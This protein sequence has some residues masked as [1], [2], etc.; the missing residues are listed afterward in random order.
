MGEWRLSDGRVVM[1]LK[2]AHSCMHKRAF[3]YHSRSCTPPRPVPSNASSSHAS[4]IFMNHQVPASSCSSSASKVYSSYYGGVETKGSRQ[5]CWTVPLGWLARHVAL[6][7]LGLF[8]GIY[9]LMLVLCIFF[10]TVFGL[11]RNK[12]GSDWEKL[13]RWENVLVAVMKLGLPLTRYLHFLLGV[14]LL[15]STV[16]VFGFGACEGATND[17]GGAFVS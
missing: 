11:F 10:A 12:F 3:F 9:L 15:A 1:Y 14:M 8:A 5:L 4:P 6:W 2:N 7:G 17:Y 16:L 13:R